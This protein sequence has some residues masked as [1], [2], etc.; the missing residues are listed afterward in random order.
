MNGVVV[1]VTTRALV[2]VSP[3][4][5]EFELD[6][7][8][9]V[10]PQTG[11]D[12][13]LFKPR[14]RAFAFIIQIESNCPKPRD[15]TGR[16]TKR[17]RQVRQK[18]DSGK[19]ATDVIDQAFLKIIWFVHRILLTSLFKNHKSEI[20]NQFDQTFGTGRTRASPL[21]SKASCCI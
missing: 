2:F 11:I 1:K 3:Q 8:A 4:I 21:V 6:A 13:A 15:I 17:V 18:P 14:H 16:I 7:I 12:S 10:T 5:A 20:I 9:E 19:D